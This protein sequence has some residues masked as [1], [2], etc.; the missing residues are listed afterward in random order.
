MN[1]VDE[2]LSWALEESRN[3]NHIKA[4]IIHGVCYRMIN[5]RRSFHGLKPLKA[6]LY[7]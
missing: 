4:G 7:K 2:L 6:R 1:A 5:R 3:K